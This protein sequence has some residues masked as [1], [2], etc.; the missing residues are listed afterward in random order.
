MV[1]F[2][3]KYGCTIHIPSK[4]IQNV[5]KKEN[6]IKLRRLKTKKSSKDIAQKL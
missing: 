6:V 5:P 3:D 1:T 4:Q 2:N